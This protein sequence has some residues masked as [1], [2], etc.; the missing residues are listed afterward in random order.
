MKKLL[1]LTFL[2]T[3]STTTLVAH[4]Q[5][6]GKAEATIGGKSVS[7]EYGRPL[8]QGRDMLARAQVGTLWRMGANQATTFISEGDLV[9]GDARVPKG[10]YT[11][12]ARKASDKVWELIFNSKV[13][14]GVGRR[15]ASNDTAA[16]PLQAES[17]AESVETF[18]IEL[19]AE[20][21]SSGSFSMAWGTLKLKASF[22][23]E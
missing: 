8:L 11:L 16:V 10:S 3:L 18:T 12:F 17:L 22:T 15:Q 7:A 5:E 13:G 20:G 9:F 4:G 14:V 1:A 23:M 19:S 6:R 21:G 2:I